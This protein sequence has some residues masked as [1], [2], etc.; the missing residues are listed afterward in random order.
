MPGTSCGK[1]M[2]LNNAL[3]TRTS[4]LLRGETE[5]ETSQRYA[6]LKDRIMG[7]LE[8]DNDFLENP[9]TELARDDVFQN[10]F[11]NL[12]H[13]NYGKKFNAPSNYDNYELSY[14][15]LNNLKQL[16]KDKLARKPRRDN[17]FDISLDSSDYYGNY[18]RRGK[19]LNFDDRYEKSVNKRK[20]N[21]RYRKRNAALKY[22]NNYK[23]SYR[24]MENEEE[25]ELGHIVKNPQNYHS[26]L[27]DRVA[28]EKRKLGFWGL[29]KWYDQ[30]FEVELMRAIKST[31]SNDYNECKYKKKKGKYLFFLRK[32]RVY[33]PPTV[34]MFLLMVMLSLP[35]LPTTLFAIT[36][37]AFFVM[38]SYYGY[39]YTKVTNMS[40]IFK[41]FSKTNKFKRKINF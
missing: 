28:Q 21:G 40:K 33:I 15:S 13:D 27:C 37:L 30:L 5:I 8:E 7:I 20:T 2:N 10:R 25:N 29:L 24:V 36:S 16:K 11:K 14:D 12:M 1:T 35:T 34:N 41:K 6:L 4:R 22:D 17:S 39:K 18:P 3:D 23:K 26:S 9:F 31:S 19:E 38:M 32:A